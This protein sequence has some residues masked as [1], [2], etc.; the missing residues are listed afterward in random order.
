[1]SPLLELESLNRQIFNLEKKIKLLV[2]NIKKRLEAGNFKNGESKQILNNATAKHENKLKHLFE[3]KKQK[4]KEHEEEKIKQGLYIHN[5][6]HYGQKE[7]REEYL[8]S[9]EW[10]QKSAA[11]LQRDPVCKICE[12]NASCD[13]HHLTYERLTNELDADLIGVCRQCHNKIHR[14]EFLSDCT[15]V[16]FIKKNIG[17][18]TVTISRSLY[19][20]ILNKNNNV[21][22]KIAAILKISVDDLSR[23][24]N[25][26]VTLSTYSQIIDCLNYKPNT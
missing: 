13:T 19:D 5:R 26:E 20:R 8:K 21:K 23:I 4:E 15:D 14:Y 22:R 3:Q 1:M 2:K 18:K 10:K 12:K 11:I 24:E 7:Y 17:K 16:S 9:S 6:I 25:G